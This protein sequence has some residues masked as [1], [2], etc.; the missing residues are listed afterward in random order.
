MKRATIAVLIG[1]LLLCGCEGRTDS[2][3]VTDSTTEMTAAVTESAPGTTETVTDSGEETTTNQTT[4]TTAQSGTTNTSAV[5]D[6]ADMA[7]GGVSDPIKPSAQD[8]EAAAGKTDTEPP[9]QT[10]TTTAASATDPDADG[11]SILTDD[12]L[13]WSPLV[14]VN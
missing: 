3:A 8:S 1:C 7:I 12:G 4:E 14:P 2:S 5:A 13:D 9:R 10:T 11:G 6:E